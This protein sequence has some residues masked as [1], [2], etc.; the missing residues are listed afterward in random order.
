MWLESVGQGQRG[1]TG[2][3]RRAE[4]LAGPA[5]RGLV[6][7]GTGAGLDLKTAAEKAKQE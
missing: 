5:V 2:R 3:R 7:W 4:R 1:G 6:G